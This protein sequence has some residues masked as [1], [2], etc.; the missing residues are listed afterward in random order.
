MYYRAGGVPT[1]HTHKMRRPTHYGFIPAKGG[2]VPS[3]APP[4][5]ALSYPYP[6]HTHVPLHRLS[7][8]YPDLF[9]RI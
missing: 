4:F 7:Y 1:R 8:P 3:H 5:T 2:L 9:W 6:D